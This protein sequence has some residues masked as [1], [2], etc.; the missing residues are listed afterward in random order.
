MTQISTLSKIPT[1]NMDGIQ[2]QVG[3]TI[4]LNQHI[5]HHSSDNVKQT[6]VKNIP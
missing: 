4:F 2:D 5:K 3:N 1:I 6:I